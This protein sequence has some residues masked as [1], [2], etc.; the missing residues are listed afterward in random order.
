MRLPL[1]VLRPAPTELPLDRQEVLRYLGYRPGVT[2][3]A[4]RHDVLVDQ[5]IALAVAAAAPAVSLGYCGI[6]VN[7]GE[8]LTRV[9]GLM[10]R[11]RA[12]SR[13]LRGGV[14]V[15]LVAAT[16]G[17]GIDALAARL[18][19]EEE[20]ALAT[21]VDAAGSAL[22]QGLA[23]CAHAYLH[24]QIQGLT[25][26]PLFGP[27]YGDWDVHDQLALVAEAGG[28]AIGL[29]TTETCYVQP[30]KSLVGVIGWIAPG[31]RRRVPTTGCDLCQMKEC[32]YR[33]RG[34][35]TG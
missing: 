2:H 3:L 12:L 11:S 26:T 27:G 20:Y 4:D 19:A 16:L 25:L 33:H 21:V 34:A 35:E 14:G 28:P 23:R 9:P 7:D 32:H 24:E 29:T 18:F 31:G 22:V 17:P 15:S 10:W 5:G 6:I 13:L 8:V 30:Q 1:T